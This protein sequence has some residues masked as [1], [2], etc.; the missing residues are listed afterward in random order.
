V[1]DTETGLAL[2]RPAAA[3]RCCD[4]QSFQ[5]LLGLKDMEAKFA[6]R[7]QKLLGSE[8]GFGRP[9]VCLRA[10][11]HLFDVAAHHVD[12]IILCD[13][14]ASRVK[15]SVAA[16]SLKFRAPWRIASRGSSSKRISHRVFNARA[17]AFAPRLLPHRSAE[18]S[19]ALALAYH[20][21]TWGGKRRLNTTQ[22]RC[23]RNSGSGRPCRE[24]KAD[25]TARIKLHDYAS[26]FRAATSR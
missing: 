11:F 16:R 15:L 25:N 17:N 8:N 18:Q 4:V 10:P 20:P 21:H 6:V 26:R 9:S 7:V 23:G 13:V 3:L 14:Y 1:R 5:W 2:I 22:S 19:Q 12:C 24:T